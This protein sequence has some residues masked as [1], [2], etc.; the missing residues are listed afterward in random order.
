MLAM[1]DLAEDL[2]VRIL[3]ISSNHIIDHKATIVTVILIVDLATAIDQPVTKIKKVT[4]ID[5]E[6]MIKTEV[7]TGGLK[8]KS[9]SIDLVAAARIHQYIDLKVIGLTVIV[10]TNQCPGIEDIDQ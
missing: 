7:D 6:V 8:Y 4:I 2:T 3:M 10:K 9:Q 5:Q 1:I